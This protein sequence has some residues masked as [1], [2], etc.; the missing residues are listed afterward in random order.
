MK[1]LKITIGDVEVR[2]KLLTEK[3]PNTIKM[4]ES[5]Q[6]EGKL[7]HSKIVEN[8]VILQVHGI[9]DQMENMVNP[10][11]GDICYWNLRQVIT[12]WYDKTVPLSK[13]N[14]WAQ[15]IPEDIPKFATEAK[16]V[17]KKPGIFMKLEFVE[18]A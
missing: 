7:N 18:E 6:L 5:L 14:L 11:A 16:K 17:W 4:L 8:E 13:A 9:M 12:I 1:K 10:T 3:A 15:I 2:A